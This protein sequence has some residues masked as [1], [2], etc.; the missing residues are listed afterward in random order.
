VHDFR[1]RHAIT[2]PII[3]IDG[4][5][6]YW[7]KPFA[8]VT[9]SQLLAAAPAG[10]D[11]TP[12]LEP[13]TKRRINL[14]HVI[15]NEHGPIFAELIDM[16]V[17]AFRQMHIETVVSRNQLCRDRLNIIIGHTAFLAA[18]NVREITSSGFR[19]VVFQLE[20]VD[21]REGFIFKYP[22]YM[23]LI[24]G[25]CGVWDYNQNNIQFLLQHGCVNVS[26]IQLGFSAVLE[27]IP[28]YSP[29]DRG[30]DVL[31]CGSITDR[32]KR[33]LQALQ[34]AGMKVQ[35]LFGVY[36]QARDQWVA[37]SKIILNLHQFGITQLEQV[38]ISYLLNN[39]CFVISESADCDLYG[40]GVIF[41]RYDDLVDCCQSY[42]APGMD[43]ERERIAQV[44]YLQLKSFP[45]LQQLR[46]AFIRHAGDTGRVL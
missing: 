41:A 14:V 6:V 26:Y 10:G 42:L 11:P 3:S 39:K 21:E 2:A 18:G 44:G 40:G 7:Q 46:S 17:D 35:V 16:L 34:D 1:S 29:H 32:R 4:W 38:R 25:A 28:H 33:V 19:Y 36:G 24:N 15:I 9:G 45:M 37:R 12:Q 5:G 31:F 27:R 43:R 8:Q 23:E 20:A 13:S 30:I 22:Y